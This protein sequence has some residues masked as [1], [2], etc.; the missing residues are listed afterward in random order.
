MITA[1]TRG[2]NFPIYTN[3]FIAGTTAVMDRSGDADTVYID[4]TPGRAVLSYYSSLN[5]IESSYMR[6]AGVS[7]ISNLSVG[8]FRIDTNHAT[9]ATALWTANEAIH[10]GLTIFNTDADNNYILMISAAA[11]GFGER[12]IQLVKQVAGVESIIDTD[13][14][15]QIVLNTEYILTL[16]RV[17]GIVTGKVYTIDG[18]LISTVS[19]A[20]TSLSAGNTGV[21]GFSVFYRVRGLNIQ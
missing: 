1:V 8:I 16:E 7:T 15:G 2:Y 5:T 3:Y 19:G 13:I 21:H 10:A 9:S 18:T 11:S 12:D 14:T 4:A 6:L 17:A 20:D